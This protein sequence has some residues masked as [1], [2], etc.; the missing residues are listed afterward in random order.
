MTPPPKIRPTRPF[1]PSRLF[2]III[3]GLSLIFLQSCRQNDP[4]SAP[5]AVSN[6]I[7][8]P[9]TPIASTAT[10]L[11][12]PPTASPV[13]LAPPPTTIPTPTTTATQSS[14][15]TT[16]GFSVQNN[17]L[18]AHWAGVGE[19]KVVIIGGREA[20]LSL[21]A[22]YQQ[23]PRN[24]PSD[25]TIWFVPAP[26][27]DNPDPN[28]LINANGINLLHNADTRFLNCPPPSGDIEPSGQN[29][30]PYPFS[31][32]ESRAIRDLLTDAWLVIFASGESITIQSGSCDAHQSATTLADLITQNT[33]TS[34]ADSLLPKG[35]FVDYLA[36]QGTAAVGMNARELD[37]TLINTIL[38]N[39]ESIIGAETQSAA[40]TLK[41]FETTNTGLWQFPPGTFTHPLALEII[42]QNLYILDRG[43]VQQLNPQIPTLPELIL[44]PDDEVAGVRVIEPIDLAADS[45]T[46][47]VLDRVGD[48][49]AYDPQTKA[50]S[51]RRY[52]RPIG[53][54]STHYYLALASQPS[55]TGQNYLLEGSYHVALQQRP[56]RPDFIW[57]LPENHQIDISANQDDV[58][59]LSQSPLSKTAELI[60]YLQGVRDTT[61]APNI[62]LYRARQIQATASELYILDYNGRR[63]MAFDSQTGN[64]KNSYLPANGHPFSAFLVNPADG[65]ILLAGK[66]RLYFHSEPFKR[67]VIQGGGSPNS[68]QLN[69]PQVLENIRGLLMPIGGSDIAIREN[70]MPGA[71]R[72]YRLG[73][74]E[75][76][77][78]Y[79]Q[80]GTLVRAVGPG[81]V[82]RATVNY[83]TPTQQL[84]DTWYRTVQALGY[85][86]P[87]AHDFYRGKQVW[88]EHEGGLISRYIHLSTID[89]AIQAGVTVQPGQIIGAVGNSGSPL[90][91]E[92]PDSDAHLHFELWLNGRYLGQFL[93]PI[94]TREWLQIILNE[95]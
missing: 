41:W 7:T 35:H 10:P 30:G 82:I 17:P 56:D 67:A 72:H 40:A 73:I 63:L 53:E 70:Q 54:T 49:Y 84:F 11:P 71:P 64:L 89:P 26:N 20:A 76:A 38:Q 60:H 83:I 86:S 92:S 33:T 34:K 50:W 19:K 69:D 8:A 47:L 65:R 6:P 4:Q 91:L 18:V 51:I 43:R 58:Y 42:G 45:Q 12:N 39:L 62:P 88:I 23:N 94:E 52:D 74:H 78:F 46:L 36:G 13:V 93:R 22:Q 21:A 55:L 15:Q 66:D 48:V 32:P 14:G 5:T 80:S 57:P 79:W 24:V 59:I 1:K 27:P 90:M 31:E 28:S 9:P 61:F 95:Q 3:V 29:P 44:A 2:P 81:T 37:I 68:L 85:T 25:L 75:G 77:D 16:I 87:E